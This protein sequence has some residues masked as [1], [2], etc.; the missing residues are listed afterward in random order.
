M[1]VIFFCA[2]RRSFD[3]ATNCFPFTHRMGLA[4]WLKATTGLYR[5][6]AKAVSGMQERAMEPLH[7]KYLARQC[8]CKQ[9]FEF[10]E[11]SSF[12]ATINSGFYTSQ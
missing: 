2:W 10:G 5:R 4:V 12:I 8:R 11:D 3:I 9:H 1:A 6:I 7:R